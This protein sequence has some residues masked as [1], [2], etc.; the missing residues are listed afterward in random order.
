MPA[1]MAL[2]PI[3]RRGSEILDQ[4]ERR[5]D[6]EPIKDEADDS[7]RRYYLSEPAGL[8]AVR[9]LLEHIDPG[10]RQHIDPSQH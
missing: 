10:W 9:V 7:I 8:D 1:V 4:L 3:D 2:R 5:T 6:L